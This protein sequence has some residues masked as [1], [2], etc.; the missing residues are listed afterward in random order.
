MNFLG[1]GSF[2]GIRAINNY[3]QHQKERPHKEK[4]S[5]SGNS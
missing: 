1:K 4:I 3:L 2:L 5:E